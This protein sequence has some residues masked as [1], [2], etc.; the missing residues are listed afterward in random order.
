MIPVLLHFGF[1]KIYTLG[2][3]LTFAFLVSSF[4]LWKNLKITSYKEEEI[5]DGLFL[6]MI[7]AFLGGRLIYVLLNFDKFGF[8]ILKFILINGYPGISMFGA[9][10]GGFITLSL[11]TQLRKI[12]FLD[13]SEYII[14]P[15]F[16][17]L[18]ISKVGSFLSGTDVGTQTKFLLSVNYVGVSGLRHITALYEAV[19]FMIGFLVT[20]RILFI[21]RRDRAKAGTSLILFIIYFGLVELILDNIKQNHLYLSGLSF[22]SIAGGTLLIIGTIFLLTT[23]R[24]NILYVITHLFSKTKKHDSRTS[25]QSSNGGPETSSSE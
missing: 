21:V 13:L 23:Y 2:V 25:Q 19:F 3:F 8:S 15:L 12:S 22:N 17:G 5:F 7:G 16:L 20:H 6:S 1:I 24:S 11:F 18:A 9:L 4:L 10:L 14:S